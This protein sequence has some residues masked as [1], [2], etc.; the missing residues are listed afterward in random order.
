MSA[1]EEDRIGQLRR[2]TICG[3][4]DAVVV[5][6]HR[7]AET[8]AADELVIVTMAHD[9]ADRLR[10]YQLIANEMSLALPADARGHDSLAE[11]VP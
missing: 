3:A 9:P 1:R 6:L 4:A 5:Q 7:I 2:A 11:S 10:S 8:F